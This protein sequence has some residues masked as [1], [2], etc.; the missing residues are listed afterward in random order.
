M[1][2]AQINL[3]DIMNGGWKEYSISTCEER[4]IPQF[5]DGLKPVQ[6]FLV[7]NGYRLAK[8]KFDKVNAIGSSVAALGY[9][10]GENSACMALTNM[11][12]YFSNN[13]PLFEGDGS[14]GNVL[15]PSPAAPRYIFAKLA[16]YIDL[17]FK[18]TN[19]APEDPDPEIVPPKYY[20]P[21][22]PICL[23]N[24]IKGLATGYAVD[25]PPHD[26]VSIIDNL[27]RLCE[28][29]PLK[30]IKPKY[31]G[32]SGEVTKDVDHYVLKGCFEK[33]SPIHYVITDIP[34]IFNTSASYEAYLRKLVDKG[35]I[36][37]YENNSCDDKFNYDI[38]L[39]KGDRWTDEDFV[40]KMKLA[41]THTWNL[42]TVMPNGKLHVWDK[43]T[44]INDMMKAF[45]E[46]RIPFIQQRIDNKI[47]ELNELELFYKGFIQFIE[48]V[49]SNKI[50]LRNI[51]EDK[52][53]DTLKNVYMIP[54]RFIERVLSAPVR[55]F[56]INKINDMKTKLAEVQ[57]DYLY[58]T[59]TTKEVEYKKDLEEL[60]TAIKKI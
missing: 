19:I 39:R 51:D 47:K 40:S 56:T 14:F 36:G 35:T 20:L 21:I 44:G 32:F 22:I 29:K 38:Y 34:S 18:D 57:K 42:T 24:G 46:F 31:Y 55:S 49:I 7:Y 26:P 60:K 13:L 25:I 30:E 48:D 17:L 2:H 27:I 50:N 8:N 45:Y 3:S 54:D 6:R 52:L 41:W 59:Q 15:D 23:L 5:A 28:N 37:S 53:S 16:S 1:N 9:E 58:Y 11:G 10:H 12:A 43:I 4:G 33:K